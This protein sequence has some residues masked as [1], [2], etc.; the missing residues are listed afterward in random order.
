MKEIL[1]A[2]EPPVTVFRFTFT[3]VNLARK[4]SGLIPRANRTLYGKGTK[5]ARTNDT[6]RPLKPPMKFSFG[7]PTK[8]FDSKA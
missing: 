6:L 7:T 2:N 8:A 4:Y 3:M 1:N 5:G